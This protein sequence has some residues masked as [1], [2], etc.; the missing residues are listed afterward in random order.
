MNEQ[1]LIKYSALAAA[2]VIT[3]LRNAHGEPYT[4]L[5]L[6]TDVKFVPQRRQWK[7]DYIFICMPTFLT[8]TKKSQTDG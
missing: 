4:F 7:Q 1:Q 2:N 3:F 8:L 5:A 6:L